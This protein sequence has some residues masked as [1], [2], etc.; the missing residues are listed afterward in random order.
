MS[1]ISGLKIKTPCSEEGKLYC[2]EII[3][4]NF[5]IVYIYIYLFINRPVTEIFH[6]EFKKLCT[7]NMSDPHVESR[8]ISSSSDCLTYSSAFFLKYYECNLYHAF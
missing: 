6:D 5:N 4:I 2:Y 1:Q 8:N 3:I 7:D